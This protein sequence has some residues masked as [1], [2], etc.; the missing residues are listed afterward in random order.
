[1]G[2]RKGYKIIKSEIIEFIKLRRYF[3]YEVALIDC[4]DNRLACLPEHDRDLFVSCG[5][6]CLDITHEDDDVCRLDGDLGLY[7]HILQDDIIRLGLDTARVDHD[8]I[9]ASPGRVCIKPV[10]GNAGRIVYDGDSLTV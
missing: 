10:S 9:P 5:K 3:A 8:K 4:A 1:M 2:S 7:P 6:T